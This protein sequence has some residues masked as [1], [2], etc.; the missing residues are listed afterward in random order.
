M[1]SQSNLGSSLPALFAI[2]SDRLAEV[3]NVQNEEFIPAC[4]TSSEVLQAL[5]YLSQKLTAQ[6]NT[7]VSVLTPHLK[8]SILTLTWPKFILVPSITFFLFRMIYTPGSSNISTYSMLKATFF[9]IQS[10]A[11]GFWKNY[12][13]EPLRE[14]FDT[15]RTGENESTRLVNPHGVQADVEVS[16]NCIHEGM[17]L[18]G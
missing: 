2:T 8:P 13:L 18:T 16:L 11:T 1:H 15:M 3:N 4:Q 9:Q 10:T 7:F 5:G 14:I 6:K 12:L 17:L